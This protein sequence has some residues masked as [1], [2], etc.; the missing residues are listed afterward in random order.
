MRKR[1]K[2]IAF[3]LLILVL[4]ALPLLFQFPAPVKGGQVSKYRTIYASQQDGYLWQDDTDYSLCN[5]YT[6]GY[7]YIYD[8][9]IKMGQR[10]SGATY[11]IYRPA[12]HFDTSVL[13]D[14]CTVNNVT[15]SFTGYSNATVGTGWN[16]S[17]YRGTPL[18]QYPSNPLVAGDYWTG[19]YYST[20]GGTINATLVQVGSYNNMTLPTNWISLTAETRFI[21]RSTK[22]VSQTAPTGDEYLEISGAETTDDPCIILGYTYE[23]EGYTLYGA[24]SEDGLRDG[25]INCTFYRPTEA[26]STFELDGSHFVEAEETGVAFHFDLGANESRVFYCRQDLQ[27]E[28]VY[29]IKPSE[30]YSVYYFKVVDLVGVEWG[31]LESLLN[32]NGTDQIVERW[33]ISLYGDLPFTMTWGVAYKMRIVTNLGIYYYADFVADATFE[34]TFPITA[35]MFEIDDTDTGDV[36]V[37]GGRMNSTWIQGSYVDSA[38][39]TTI[40]NMTIYVYENASF[41][42]TTEVSSS[43]LTYN[44]YDAE[45]DESYFI[46]IIATHSQSG[47]LTYTFWC[48]VPSTNVNPFSVLDVLLGD[49]LPFNA[50]ELVGLGIVLLF[51]GAF[52]RWNAAVGLVVGILIAAL[53]G[54]LAWITVSYEW[55]TGSM[56]IAIIIAISIYKDKKGR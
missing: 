2:W 53:F 33:D 23:S 47:E 25:A 7:A 17:A 21:L 18:N 39:L 55:L 24:Y 49:G 32:L 30:P 20:A 56:G 6:T 14:D 44:W 16:I 1:R 37:S 54:F 48:P 43:S 42:V 19:K 8:Q 4:V 9:N 31:Y 26:P 3:P 35:D 5:V 34:W 45:E 40:I 50:S 41:V 27:T 15:F 38:G 51:V 12:F 28:T 46:R 13:P 29:V 36:S 11:Y 52:S 22:D 10:L